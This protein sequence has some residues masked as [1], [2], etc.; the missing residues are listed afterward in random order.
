[1][2]STLSQGFGPLSVVSDAM[3][4]AVTN[5]Q[6]CSQREESARLKTCV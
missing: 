6:P 1:V 5:D 3:M 2:D 4:K